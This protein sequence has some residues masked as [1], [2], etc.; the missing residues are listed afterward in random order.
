MAMA[1][2]RTTKRAPHAG[3]P[4]VQ[5]AIRE[6]PND[7][8]DWLD[9]FIDKYERKGQMIFTAAVFRDLIDL[10]LLVALLLHRADGHEPLTCY[11]LVGF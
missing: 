9:C 4:S 10:I 2:R 6:I 11:R 8:I 3:A 7:N 5:A 1:C